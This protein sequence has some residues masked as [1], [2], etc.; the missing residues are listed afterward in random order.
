MKITSVTKYVNNVQFEVDGEFYLF[1]ID[2][3]KAKDLQYALDCRAKQ[4]QAETATASKFEEIKKE[5]EN[6]EVITNA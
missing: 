1:E 6:K 4:A 2:S 3:F 5:Y